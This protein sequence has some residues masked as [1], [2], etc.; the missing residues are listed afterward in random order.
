MGPDRWPSRPHLYPQ[1][2]AA[3]A[4]TKL[5]ELVGPK[6]RKGYRRIA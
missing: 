5:L 1:P 4:Q 3:D 6:E 2:A